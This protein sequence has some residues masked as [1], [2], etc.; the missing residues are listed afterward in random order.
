M[1]TTPLR[2]WLEID[3]AALRHNLA[4]I[5]KRIG[6]GPQVIAAVK[7]NGYGHGMIP[8]AREALAAGAAVL[9]VADLDELRA[10]RRAEIAAPVLLFDPALAGEFPEIVS[11]DGWVTLSTYREAAGLDRAAKKAGRIAEAHLKVDTGMG[12]VG[13]APALAA[14]ELKRIL[15]LRHVRIMAIY[16]HF[17]SA[18]SDPVLTRRQL[19][20][21]GE[22]R[23]AF[24]TLPWHFANSPALLHEPKA[25]RGSAYVRAGLALYGL[26]PRP[27][28]RAVLRPVLSWK[29]RIT[30]VRPLE[31]GATVSYGATYRL[32]RAE[33]LATIAVGYGDGYPRMLSN[34]ASVLVGGRRC[35]IRGRVT[36]DQIVVDV[37]RVP[38]GL[39]RA[40]AEVVLL[41]RQ[42]RQEITAD[43]LARHA[44]T[45][46]YEIVTRTADRLPRLYL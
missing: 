39:A 38:G 17:A 32:P 42:G 25:F 28:D 9:G 8:V 43:E 36:M 29:A 34:R 45:I 35:P 20:A 30:L 44:E 23:Q 13:L 22:V 10:L 12:R 14:A 16:S 26:P 41:G 5:R 7:A 11:L 6:T 15:R 27:T 18:D 24:P 21:F 31:K 4:A 3:R 19:A 46:S 2:T 37:S 40:G 33:R 1:P